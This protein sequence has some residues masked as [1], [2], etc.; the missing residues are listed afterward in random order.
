[1]NIL[2]PVDSRVADTQGFIITNLEDGSL[3]GIETEESLNFLR[4]GFRGG[5]LVGRQLY[6]CNSFSF[7]I[8]AIEKSSVEDISFSLK[9][10]VQL[11]EW[12]IGSGANADLH[13]LCYDRDRNEL[14]LAN[15]Y[16]DCID[17]FSLDGDFLRRKFLWEISKSIRDLIVSRNP[18]AA[19]L[20]HLNHIE[21]M[22]DDILLTLGN[23]NATGMGQVI[24]MSNGEV[25][26]DGLHRPHDGVYATNQYVITET[27]K[28][29]ILV[30]DKILSAEDL[31][32]QVPRIVNLFE[33]Y[34]ESPNNLFWARGL[35]VTGKYILVGC[36][37]FQDRKKQDIVSAPSHLVVIDR[38]SLKIIKRIEIQTVG[39]LEKPVLYSLI[40]FE[41]IF[42]NE[43]PKHCDRI[44][45]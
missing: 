37:Q 31:K 29:R 15:S 36:S 45:S 34:D 20:C 40:D 22:G 5:C 10:Q 6:V 27:N 39:A 18:K 32:I 9:K 14:L 2:L 12:L 11:P 38:Y 30:Y 17:V 44:S 13:M 8:Y 21:K 24:N 25:V 35:L 3:R 43:K 1:M 33:D 26:L 4:K 28:Q 16:M 23:L 7:K 41:T 19:D 42:L